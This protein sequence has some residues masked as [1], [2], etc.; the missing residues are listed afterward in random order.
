MISNLRHWGVGVCI[1]GVLAWTV[2][3]GVWTTTAKN[4]DQPLS[5]NT[6]QNT[7]SHDKTSDEHTYST[8]SSTTVV[9]TSRQLKNP[10]VV[11]PDHQSNTSEESKTS[12]VSRTPRDVTVVNEVFST[13]TQVQPDQTADISSASD[14]Q[15]NSNKLEELSGIVEPSELTSIKSDA[16]RQSPS[17][18]ADRGYIKGRVL[19]ENG[20]LV[21]GARVSAVANEQHKPRS[22]LS[23]RRFHAISDETG[24]H[25]EDLPPG[26]Y[27][28]MVSDSGPG[29]S[30]N[31]T[32]RTNQH[33]LDFVLER[34][35]SIQISGQILDTD[36]VA[37]SNAVI[38]PLMLGA[39]HSA[40]DEY[41]Q[42]LMNLMVD[43]G[44]RKLG[45][46]VEHAD[47]K[48]VQVPVDLGSLTDSISKRID[49]ILQKPVQKSI[50]AHGV[51]RSSSV[52]VVGMRVALVSQLSS[53]QDSVLTD[54]EGYF[55]ITDVPS[56][57]SFTITLDGNDQY[58]SQAIQG[59][60][61]GER[62]TSYLSLSVNRSATAKLRGIVTDSEG[63]PAS[64]FSLVLR[65]KDNS[66]WAVPVVGNEQGSFEVEN[67]PTGE[68][69]FESGVQPHFSFRGIHVN[70]F[71]D[72]FVQLQLPRGSMTL[73][74]VV[75]DN[76]GN[77]IA[78]ANVV[79]VRSDYANG[80]ISFTRQVV[81]SDSLGK[82]SLEHLPSGGNELIV[83]K[84]GY[85]K[86]QITHDILLN[87]SS[88]RFE[89]PYI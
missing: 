59:V 1:A 39:R 34:R 25:L 42:F 48:N 7:N 14:W 51:V 88:V 70:S 53:F 38:K 36:F 21:I 56:N 8:R 32:V 19:Y 13:A 2:I 24:F 58:A 73:A 23:S 49:I 5:I 11:V 50:V 22:E 62:D 28:V 41:G 12:S 87:G 45:L 16:D 77:P 47:Y 33:A 81:E 15:D 20:L 65:S 75:T 54:E 37:V 57:E 3:G 71:T 6:L 84:A 72:N 76:I 74:G 17:S 89:L 4:E 18:E 30:Q 67:V 82:F 60:K 10:F 35:R 55:R 85:R 79:F 61:F 83:S 40:T 69:Y 31:K 68:V 78:N 46:A 9:A 27:I 86:Q 29:K 43:A 80:I 52:G 63:N 44:K 26:E 64:Q 66:Q